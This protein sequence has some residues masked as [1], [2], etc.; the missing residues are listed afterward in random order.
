MLNANLW[1]NP[2]IRFMKQELTIAVVLLAI[3]GLLWLASPNANFQSQQTTNGIVQTDANTYSSEQLSTSSASE[4]PFAGFSNRPPEPQIDYAVMPASFQQ[5]VTSNGSSATAATAAQAPPSNGP[6]PN[7]SA[8]PI[9]SPRPRYL[10]EASNPSAVKLLADAATG[11]AKS[12][13]FRLKVSLQGRLFQ[14]EVAANGN[15]YQMGQG[16]HKTKIE[17][18]FD[19]MPGNPKMLQLCDGRFIYT[20][21][22]SDGS[23][24]T[25]NT[26]ATAS[27]QSLEFVDL[28]RVKKATGDDFASNPGIVS[29]TGWVATGGIASLLQHLASGFNFGPPEALDPNSDRI[30]IRGGWD[31]NALRGVVSDLDNNIRLGSPIQWDKVP[32]HIPH[33]IEMVLVR[34][35]NQTYFPGQISYLR[36]G[37]RDQQATIEPSLSMTFSPPESLSNIEDG[38]FVIDSSNLEPTDACLLYTSP[39]PRDRG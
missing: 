27:R 13:P 30:L 7:S 11:I 8:A 10:Y 39:S 16:S 35:S 25:A 5:P 4:Y 36:F 38:F 6:N 19:Q 31:E 12:D 21:H 3:G 2:H 24:A 15:Y 37:M 17:L 34:N 23:A 29:P 14:Q 22:S 9:F 33:V 18:S 28:L 20:I 26:P 1:K 32:R